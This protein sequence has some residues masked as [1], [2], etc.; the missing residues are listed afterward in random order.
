[1]MTSAAMQSTRG[2]T[3][4]RRLFDG[5]PGRAEA[6]AASPSTSPAAEAR[7]R[8]GQRVW[9]FHCPNPD[10]DTELV[11]FPEYAG[12][13]VQCPTCGFAFLAPRVVPLRIVPEAEGDADAGTPRPFAPG[14]VL[15]RPGPGPAEPRPP[16]NARGAGSDL[17]A[18]TASAAAGRPPKATPA[19]VVAQVPE[20]AHRGTQA[21]E[22]LSALARTVGGAARPPAPPD[23]EP[24][25]KPAAGPDAPAGQPE[26][27]HPGAEAARRALARAADGSPARAATPPGRRTRAGGLGARMASAVFQPDRRRAKRL[28]AEADTDPRTLAHGGPGPETLPP[29]G[30]SPPARQ[31]TDLVATWAVAAVISAGLAL[32]A[33]VTGVPDIGLGSLLFLALAGMR[34]WWIVRSKGGSEGSGGA[35]PPP[36]P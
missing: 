23:A 27:G 30:Q 24:A 32:A 11:I 18:A 5:L 19:D 14:A 22:A 1:M 6:E 33:Y 25:S 35:G 31:R 36:R 34:T 3:W 20:T 12:A 4:R 17:P 16:G 26:T 15:A 10:C 9:A 7:D 29:E 8:G 13:A 21:A 28:P 2:K